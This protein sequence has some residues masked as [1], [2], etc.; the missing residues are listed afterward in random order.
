M[1]QKGDICNDGA[2]PRIDWMQDIKRIVVG[3]EQD[4]MLRGTRFTWDR[5]TL[6]VGRWPLNCP[7]VRSTELSTA[8]MVDYA[9]CARIEIAMAQGLLVRIGRGHNDIQTRTECMLRLWMAYK[10]V[11][12]ILAQDP[13]CRIG[14]KRNDM[15]IYAECMRSL[16]MN[17]K[18]IEAIM[19]RVGAETPV[20]IRSQIQ[21]A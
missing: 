10:W 8:D 12:T 13:P 21:A 9:T 3:L 6:S 17:H 2:V 18:R 20:Q 19:S 1:Q 16:R 4:G 7:P 14:S 11:K 5:D 15:Q